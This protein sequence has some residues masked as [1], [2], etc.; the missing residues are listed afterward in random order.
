MSDPYLNQTFGNVQ[1]LE[2]I[3]Q[4]G[5]GLVYRGRH[6][7]FDK[8]V[9]IKLLPPDKADESASAQQRFI[10]EGRMAASI[11]HRNVVQVLDAGTEDDVAYMILELVPG[12]NI[13]AILD[14]RERMDPDEVLHLAE[15]I[16]E[17]L[18]AIH[19]QGVV[20]RD[21][22]PDNLLLGPDG[23]VKITDL[24]LARILDDPD[25]QRLTAT[26]MVVAG[27]PSTTT[28]PTR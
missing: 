20:H 15:G 19:A 27:P 9:A 2:K 13:G 16:A 12:K 23:V 26:G 28:R 24:G 1:V 5:M 8:D 25:L 10:R 14:E 7:R 3:G 22:K 21:I 11:H 4:G 17:G 6:L 18:G